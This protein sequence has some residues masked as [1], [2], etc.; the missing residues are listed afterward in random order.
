MTPPHARGQHLPVIRLVLPNVW[1]AE[2]WA[3]GHNGTPL[4][5]LPHLWGEMSEPLPWL[6]APTPPHVVDIGVTSCMMESVIVEIEHKLY[7]TSQFYTSS[8]F[9]LPS[10]LYSRLI[11]LFQLYCMS[12]TGFSP[13]FH[14]SSTACLYF[15]FFCFPAFLKAPKPTK[16]TLSE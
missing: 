11:Y 15:F 4:G 3:R 6:P 14:F 9:L 10:V 8:C 16:D 12:I 2:R 5:S 13:F 1:A 7:F